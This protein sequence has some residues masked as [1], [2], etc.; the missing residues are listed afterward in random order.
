MKWRWLFQ[1]CLKMFRNIHRPTSMGSECPQ[2]AH[3]SM[4]IFM[5]DKKH[6]ST[7]KI[8]EARHVSYNVCRRPVPEYCHYDITDILAAHWSASND[9][10]YIINIHNRLYGLTSQPWIL[11]RSLPAA[12]K[13]HSLAN[14]K[15]AAITSHTSLLSSKYCYLLHCLQLFDELSY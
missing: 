3:L 11:L 8:S 4:S 10:T 6:T 9:V 15:R 1:S 14:G 13:V 2:R 7:F 12:T 5:S